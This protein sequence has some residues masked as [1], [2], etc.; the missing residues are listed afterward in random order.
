MVEND[1][2][3]SLNKNYGFNIVSIFKNEDSSVGNVYNIKT[4]DNKYILKIYDNINYV[5]NMI[6]IYNYLKDMYIPQIIATKDGKYFSKYNN[7][8]I[9]IYSFLEGTR[10]SEITLDNDIELIAKEVRK[11]HDL[12]SN[13]KFNLETIDFADNL[14]RQSMLHFDLTKDNIFVHGDKVGF[15][16]FD[17][18]KYGDS[19]C[20]VAILLSLLFVSKRNGVNNKGIRLFLDN[21]YKES[22]RELKE[23]EL[24]YIKIYIENWIDYILNNHNFDSSLKGSFEFKKKSISNMEILN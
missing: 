21:Y 2:E 10:I 11:L 16:D 17:D 22:E 15:I 6:G 4:V 9:V 13:K 12:T 5:N 14:K 18:A 3:N 19:V 7:S 20:D 23:K 24:S 1:L 8:Y